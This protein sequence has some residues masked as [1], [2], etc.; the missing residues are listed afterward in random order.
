MIVAGFCLG[1]K[2]LY[3]FIDDNPMVC[4]SLRERER[5]TRGRKTQIDRKKQSDG[6]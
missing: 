1:T 2:K 3:D 6:K 5:G 4:N